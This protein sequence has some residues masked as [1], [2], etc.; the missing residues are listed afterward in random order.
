MISSR[1]EAIGEYRK[2]LKVMIRSAYHLVR[3]VIST[4][5]KDQHALSLGGAGGGRRMNTQVPG[6]PTL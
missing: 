4:A 2:L 1:D 3:A 5:E 6:S